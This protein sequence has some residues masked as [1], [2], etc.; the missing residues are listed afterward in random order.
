MPTRAR[1]FVLGS[2]T[3]ARCGAGVLGVRAEPDKQGFKHGAAKRALAVGRRF[4]SVPTAQVSEPVGCA[5][6]QQRALPSVPG[7]ENT[8]LAREFQAP[9][10]LLE[11]RPECAFDDLRLLVVERWGEVREHDVHEAV[12]Q[13][14]GLGA[15]GI[16]RKRGQGV[17]EQGDRSA[18]ARLVREVEIEAVTEPFDRAPLQPDHEVFFAGE[19]AV[20]PTHGDI[21]ARGDLAQRESDEPVVDDDRHGSIEDRLVLG[22]E[23]AGSTRG[24]LRGG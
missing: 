1:F 18:A 11:N 4:E 24:A 20:Q 7:R 22:G 6:Q 2:L 21:E 9:L 8:T 3:S 10:R 13:R 19:V 12:L 23:L 16:E 14:I 15:G 17:V 5:P